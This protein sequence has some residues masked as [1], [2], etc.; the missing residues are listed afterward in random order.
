MTLALKAALSQLDPGN[1]N[2][3]TAEGLPRIETVRLLSQTPSL[4]REQLVEADP[5][6]N[7]E[8]AKAAKAG[9]APAAVPAVPA[10]PVDPVLAPKEA[11][12]D[13]APAKAASMQE[14]MEAALRVAVQKRDDLAAKKAKLDNE[15]ADAN[16]V[17]DKLSTELDK[18]KEPP[19]QTAMH[20]IMAYQRAQERDAAERAARVAKIK[21]LGITRQDLASGSALDQAMA[22]K[23]KK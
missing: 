8:A 21:D 23:R 4:T 6:F 13:A 20:T 11:T 18:F 10:A 17:V 16:F 1:D 9:A 3:W 12:Q 19:H 2:H 22:A 14:E 5:A 7:R 15:Y